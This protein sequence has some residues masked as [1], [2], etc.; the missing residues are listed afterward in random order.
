[1]KNE[2]EQG[3]LLT[4]KDLVTTTAAAG[5]AAASAVAV[6]P[7]AASGVLALAAVLVAVFP[8]VLA[9]MTEAGARRMKGR[10]DRFFDTIVKEW[11]RDEERTPEEVAGRLEDAKDD[12]NVAD[13]IWRSVR[14]LMEAPNEAAAVPLGVLAA[15]YMRD[16][17]AADAYF[18]GVVRVFQELEA[19]EFDELRGLLRWVTTATNRAEVEIVARSGAVDAALDEFANDPGVDGQPEK[20]TSVA[21]VSDPDRLFSLLTTNG[22]AVSRPGMRMDT[23][24]PE[25][26]LRRDTAARLLRLLLASSSA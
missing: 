20:R 7:T 17:R 24:L 23:G 16:K 14:G 11:A 10:A 19:T 13:A 26:I 8:P 22:L 6:S 3:S 9:L 1:M 5:A 21:V 2:K 15:E 25:I 18:R 12:P 4:A